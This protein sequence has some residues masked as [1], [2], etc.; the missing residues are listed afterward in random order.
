MDR[1]RKEEVVG[2]LN[3]VFS[4][5]KLVVVTHFSGLTASEM[6]QLRGQMRELG[7][8]FRVT[9]NRLV[10]RALDGT[11]CGPLSELFDG[12]TGIA[13]SEDPIAAAKAAVKF[14]EKNDKLVVLGGMMDETVLDA[15]GVKSLAKLSSLDELRSTIIS[16]IQTPATRVAGVLQAPA[17]QLAR[18]MGAYGA[19]DEAA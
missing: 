6:N 17:G 13:Y 3:K 5:S 2:E 8:T 10:R 9:K 14:S 11:N 15:G 7:A 16:I 18:V 19:K 1:A 12:P 4:E